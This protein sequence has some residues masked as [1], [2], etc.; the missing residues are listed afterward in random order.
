LLVGLANQ[1]VD[2]E[3]T[4]GVRVSCRAA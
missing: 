4:F 1:G 2:V 3:M